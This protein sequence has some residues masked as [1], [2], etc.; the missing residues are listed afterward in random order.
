[1]T[2]AVVKFKSRE[3]RCY[4]VEYQAATT[5]GRRVRV[6]AD[7]DPGGHDDVG[8]VA[9]YAMVRRVFDAET[10]AQIVELP[11]SDWRDLYAAAITSCEAALEQ[12]NIS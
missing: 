9:K 7:Y 10:G 3:P 2:A 4:Q 8:Y 11:D 6:W 12:E 5:S 1:M